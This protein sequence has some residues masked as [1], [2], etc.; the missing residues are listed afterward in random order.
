MNSDPLY[1]EINYKWIIDLT[2]TIIMLAQICEKNTSNQSFLLPSI[3]F[4]LFFT[5][6]KLEVKNSYFFFVFFLF[7]ILLIHCANIESFEF[8]KLDRSPYQLVRVYLE[9]NQAENQFGLVIKNLIRIS[10]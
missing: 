3:T 10:R 9:S 5:K 6:K 2:L 4:Q 1:Q 7:Y 8:M